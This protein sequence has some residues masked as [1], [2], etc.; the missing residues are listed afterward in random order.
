VIQPGSRVTYALGLAGDTETLRAY[1]ESLTP[2]LNPSQ[3]FFGPR[4]GG[5]G[6]GRAVE[7]IDRYIG[8][9]GLLAVILAGV[10]I[11][12]AARRYSA[13]HYDASA[14]LRCLGCTQRDILQI[15]LPQLL[16]LG[17]LASMAGCVLGFVVQE[18]IHSLVRSLFPVQ[19]PNA[20]A[21]P[22]AYG[23]FTG[24]L[25][26][27]GFGVAPVLRLKAVPPL[28]VLRRE[29]TPLPA[30]AWAVAILA[31]SALLVL[32]WDYTGNATLLVG[33]IGGASAAAGVLGA[34]AWALLRLARR[35]RQRVGVAWRFSATTVSRR[36]R[37]IRW[38]AAVWWRS[39]ARRCGERSR[40]KRTTPT[41]RYSV[42]SI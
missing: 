14:M 18:A 3:R 19:L 31:G 39:M 36:R 28:R 33:V 4:E 1:R 13:R 10:A 38:C 27:T 26:L 7:R 35:L 41:Q 37:C 24:L 23:M 21:A 42:T 25:V 16:L 9:T 8:L 12:M 22:I 29:L 5:T 11:A 17:L 20:G 32:L 34:L 40:K 30:S 15:Y 6:I 2:Q